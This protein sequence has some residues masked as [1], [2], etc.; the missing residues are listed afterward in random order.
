MSRVKELCVAMKDINLLSSY[1][2]TEGQIIAYAEKILEI[3]PDATGREIEVIMQKFF[4]DEIEFNPH[5]GVRNFT[6]NISTTRNLPP[7][8]YRAANGQ[9][10][11]VEP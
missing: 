7:G 3:Y 4:K 8:H 11:K 2:F 5:R 10:I 6:G 1:E 9:I